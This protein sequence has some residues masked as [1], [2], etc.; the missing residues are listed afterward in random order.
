M[1]LL[2]GVGRALLIGYGMFR[3]HLTSEVSSSL[4]ALFWALLLLAPTILFTNEASTAVKVLL[5][6]IVVANMLL[7]GSGLGM[8]YAV[9][10]VGEGVLD[11]LRLS[12]V[13]VFYYT[14]ST[15][16]LELVVIGFLPFI[17][18]VLIISCYLG[19]GL[20][21][22]LS[23]NPSVLVA[24]IP[25]KFA[26]EVFASTASCLLYLKNPFSRS[27]FGI[28][29]IALL[30]IVFIPPKYLPAAFLDAVVP[31][32]TAVEVLRLAYGSNTIPAGNL[33][34]SSTIS[35]IFLTALSILSSR[36]VENHISRYGVEARY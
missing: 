14:A 33:V 9:W 10:L 16:P 24:S 36:A 3:M 4:N 15:F 19:I 29:Q 6:A 34:A 7:L 2:K 27:L 12:G 28:I 31:G 8:E 30:T 23:F 20:A 26:S 22:F 5:P 35:T 32:L 17:L 18:S 21:W 1:R 25:V 11:D 13:S